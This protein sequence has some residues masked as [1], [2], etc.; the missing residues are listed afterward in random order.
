MA[1]TCA[2]EQQ[3]VCTAWRRQAGGDRQQHNCAAQQ[4]E[5]LWDLLPPL[6]V[7]DAWSTETLAAYA[8]GRLDVPT[9]GDLRKT[10][11]ICIHR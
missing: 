1:R 4:R 6:N 11:Y 7:T 9:E 3:V 5:S 8:H 2:G 10:R